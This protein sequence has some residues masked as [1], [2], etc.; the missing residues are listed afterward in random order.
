[1]TEPHAIAHQRYSELAPQDVSLDVLAF[2]ARGHYALLPPL[3]RA[4]RL[5][6]IPDQRLAGM[7]YRETSVAA[8]A[9]RIPVPEAP[10]AG[11]AWRRR[12]ATRFRSAPL[13]FTQV[14]T[15]L[16]RTLVTQPSD[17]RHARMPY[18]SGGALYSVIPFLCRTAACIA[19][20]PDVS[21]AFQVM[22][23]SRSL[24]A[25]PVQGTLQHMLDALSGGSAHA[26][27]AP[28]FAIVYAIHLDKAVFKYRYRGFRLA[29]ME[30]GSMY[31]RVT[32]QAETVG[33]ASRVWAGFSDCQVGALLG[34]DATQVLPMVVQFLGREDEPC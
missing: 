12:S 15:L 2:N 1:M 18:P 7:V 25:L 6:G 14:L 33:L 16:S 31:Q 5:T 21:A 10:S 13:H 19:D 8:C 28:A 20:W 34:I 23:M 29:Q 32:E 11:V 9:E 24:E 17:G 26:L 3:G 22:P 27:G 4:V 30:V